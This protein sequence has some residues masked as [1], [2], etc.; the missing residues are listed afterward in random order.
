MNFAKL[1]LFRSGVLPCA[2]L[3]EAEEGRRLLVFSIFLS[4]ARVH[5]GDCSGCLGPGGGDLPR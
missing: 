4:V 3:A 1:S 2:R 5:P